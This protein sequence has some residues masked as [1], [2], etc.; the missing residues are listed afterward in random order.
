MSFCQ[1]MHQ[2]RGRR[3]RCAK[4]TAEFIELSREQG[5]PLF[6]ASARHLQGTAM[7]DDGEVVR[8]SRSCKMAPKSTYRSGSRPTSRL[9]LAPWRTA[10]GKAGML[11]AAI[12]H[13]QTSNLHGRQVWRA[14]EQG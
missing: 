7:V 11:D 2:L 14:M 12:G 13:H 3:R 9:G 6:L 5:Y 4:R 1:F 10:L 8:V